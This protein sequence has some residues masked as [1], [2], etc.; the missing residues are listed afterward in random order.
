MCSSDL[1]PADGLISRY[2]NR[3]FS[4]N[5]FT[6]LLLR[7]D[8]KITP[9]QVSILSFVVGLISSVCFFIGQGVIGG[10]LIQISSILDGSD[11][12]IA[13]LK[14]MQSSLGDF[15][16]A[17]LD[18]YADG[19]ILLG[20]FY[21]SLTKVGGQEILGIY[22]SPL[23]I[24]IISVLAI[25]GNVMVSYTSAKSVVNFGY[26]Y[27]GKWIAAGRGR[28]LRLFLLFIGG[29]M[30][31]FHPL[32]V[33]SALLITAIQT[34][35]I[36]LR[37]T[38]LS[39]SYYLNK[40]FL[41]KGKIK[42]VIF[43]FDGTIADTMPFL[44]GLAI[45]LMT[46]NYNI[47][48]GEAEKRYLET[49]GMDF[50]T[51]LEFIFPH[52][53]QNQKVASIFEAKKLAGIFDHPVFPEVIP[54]LKHFQDKKIKTFICSSTKQ[55]II[56][57]YSKLNKI[58]DCITDSFGLKTDC[59]KGEQVRFILQHYKLQPDEVLFVGDSLRDYDFIKTTKIKFIGICRIFKKIEF[60]KRGLLSV[61]CLTDILKLFIKSERTFS[62]VKEV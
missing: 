53:S 39:W 61:N 41:I 27:K 38:F 52:H 44:T 31:Y 57:R 21:Y 17:V 23:M 2:I 32:W 36:V 13:R 34:N 22:W 12:E 51:Q 40:N 5:I 29:I 59:G 56:T 28:D 19:L 14:H 62:S 4:V 33:L 1:K 26:Q 6:P 58:D 37:R 30:S 49:T 47:S 43:D 10:V 16:D 54:V 45:K 60:Q 18:R 24:S 15:I 7:I 11:G 3:K 8:R 50:A 46:E 42:A 25:L 48:K 9:N 55:E 35:A 20:M